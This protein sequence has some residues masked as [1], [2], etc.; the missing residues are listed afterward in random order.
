MNMA[1]VASKVHAGDD[2]CACELTYFQWI[3]CGAAAGSILWKLAPV[4]LYHQ[5]QSVVTAILGFSSSG[6]C[7]SD[8]FSC[9]RQ[10]RMLDNSSTEF[11][12]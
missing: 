6:D 5:A 9:D 1:N 10:I 11:Q 4:S 7:A 8:S 2:C 12:A 3:Q